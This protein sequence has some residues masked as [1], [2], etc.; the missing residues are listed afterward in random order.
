MA[1]RHQ[2]L[3]TKNPVE[4]ATPNGNVAQSIRARGRGAGVDR[5]CD[6]RAKR[7][8]RCLGWLNKRSLKNVMVEIGRFS[9]QIRGNN[10]APAPR[11]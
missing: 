2:H 7:A 8:E 1:R 9:R 6:K 10:G 3:R 4:E 5:Q 11:R